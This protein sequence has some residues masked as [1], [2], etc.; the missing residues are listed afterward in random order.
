MS[1]PSSISTP[2]RCGLFLAVKG[3]NGHHLRAGCTGIS[4]SLDIRVGMLEAGKDR[5]RFA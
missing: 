5:S 2:M 1:L 3:A 4:A